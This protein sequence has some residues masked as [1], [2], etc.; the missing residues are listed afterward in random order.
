[1]L[2]KESMFLRTSVTYT[3]SSKK[4][5]QTSPQPMKCMPHDFE[6]VLPR[7]LTFPTD[8][9]CLP[10]HDRLHRFFTTNRFVP[11]AS[12]DTG[13]YSQPNSDLPY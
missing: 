6:D 3:L 4:L 10:P 13:Q 9:Q 2:T 7:S 5:L 1:M 11:D 8:N 12:E